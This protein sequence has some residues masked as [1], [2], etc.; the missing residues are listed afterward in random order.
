MALPAFI[1]IGIRTAYLKMQHKAGLTAETRTQNPQD[2][3]LM[4]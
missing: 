2:R 4:R 1:A 3:S